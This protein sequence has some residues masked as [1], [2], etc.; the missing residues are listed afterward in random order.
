[1]NVLEEKTNFVEELNEKRKLYTLKNNEYKELKCKLLL[2]TNFEKILDKSRPTV[3]EKEAYV[4]LKTIELKK[5]KELLY[6]DI[7]YLEMKIDLCN[8]KI[9]LGVEL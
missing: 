7:K 2:E 9:N 1:M 8:D 3:G 4:D 5:E 6:D